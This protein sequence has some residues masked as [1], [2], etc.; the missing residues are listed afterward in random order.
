MPLQ[1]YCHTIT[2][3]R[4]VIVMLDTNVARVWACALQGMYHGA[5]RST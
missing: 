4:V 5:G 1:A 3:T 2:L